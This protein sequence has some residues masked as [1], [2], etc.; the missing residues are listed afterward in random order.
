MAE[1]A[2]N[3]TENKSIKTTPFFADNR[4]HPNYTPRR[5][6]R[7]G[8]EI[9]STETYLEQQR[10]AEDDIRVAITLA[11]NKNKTYYDNRSN[12]SPMYKTGDQV[13]LS[14]VDPW[15]K[16]AA[17]K[18]VRPSQKLEDRKFGPYRIKRKLNHAYELELPPTMKIHPVIHES[19]LLPY[20]EDT[21][22][23][24]IPPQPPII[25]EKGEEYQVE[26]I[27]ASRWTKHKPL[28]FQYR[29]S[30]LGYDNSHD[31]WEPVVNVENAP[32]KLLL[33]HTKNP[34]APKPTQRA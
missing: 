12:K 25:T 3:N 28:R 22:K 19:R 13:W 24:V 34:H 2:Y 10:K 20:H 30:W 4:R 9:P 8:T 27:V 1:F 29:V 26:R 6:N 11:G 17:V 23:R 15:T 33:Y 21:L 18:T 31:T 16:I 32:K 7:Q 14:R 5:L